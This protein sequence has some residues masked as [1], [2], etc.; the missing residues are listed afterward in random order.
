V[1]L[2]DAAYSRLV[3]MPDDYWSS[4][5]HT[6]STLL[7][8]VEAVTTISAFRAATG[9]RFVWRGVAGASWSLHS[10]LVHRLVETGQGVPTEEGLREREEAIL[11]E[12]RAWSLDWHPS[13]G[14]LTALELLAGL[15]HYGVPTRML[16][17]TFNPLIALWFAV[18]KHPEQDGRLFA[19]DISNRMATREQ[20]EH[21][22]PWW[23]YS[24]PRTPTW[25]TESWIW[26]PPPL[27]PRIVRQEGCFLMGGIPST[28][29]A[30]NAKINGVWG[31]LRADEVKACMSVPFRL[32]QYRQAQDAVKGKTPPGKSPQAR[33]FTVRVTHKAE[34]R[35][36]LEQA[37]GYT[38]SSLYPDFSGLAEHGRSF[39][40]KPAPHARTALGA[41]GGL[42][43]PDVADAVAAIEKAGTLG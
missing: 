9:A 20:A 17:F 25:S 1:F 15:Q 26:K 3:A 37:F 14:R 16:D 22:D 21:P 30:R 38:H 5:E 42:A 11:A 12:A 8:F 24:E 41:G 35:V 18:E 40:H 28:Q 13:G 32:I 2:P 39:P 43:A 19:I 4:Y 31:L 10:S 27:E 36:E 34:I 29:P 23:F 33:A 6:V 7:G